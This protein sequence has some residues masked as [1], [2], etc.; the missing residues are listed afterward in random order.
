MYTTRAY[1]KLNQ[2]VVIIFSSVGLATPR[3]VKVQSEGQIIVRP[4]LG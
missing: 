2:P 1:W 4:F 3:C